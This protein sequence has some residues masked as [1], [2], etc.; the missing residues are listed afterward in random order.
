MNNRNQLYHGYRFPP[1]I[2]SHAAWVY[3]RFCPSFRDV[4]DHLAERGMVVSYETIRSW[5][6]SAAE[7]FHP[8]PG[9]KISNNGDF[10]H[11][12]LECVAST[13]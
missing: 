10:C 3:H 13:N 9:I 5:F 7:G 1:E 4:E 8:G 6:N 11:E 2:F 12:V